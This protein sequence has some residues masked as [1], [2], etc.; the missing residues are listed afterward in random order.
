MFE[1]E[2]I[3]GAP[4]QRPALPP[5]ECMLVIWD[6]RHLRFGEMADIAMGVW[7][8]S[9]VVLARF[10][11][12][13][14]DDIY[15]GRIGDSR[16]PVGLLFPRDGKNWKRIKSRVKGIRLVLE[17]AC[18]ACEGN[19]KLPMVEIERLKCYIRTFVTR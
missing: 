18:L 8:E 11:D 12:G 9:C 6:P 19:G 2:T 10:N 7:R 1:K 4:W 16:F 15:T 3:L 5:S 14:T 13:T 17:G